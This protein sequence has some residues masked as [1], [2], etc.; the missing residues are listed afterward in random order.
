MLREMTVLVVDDEPPIR[1]FITLMLGDV[2]HHVVTAENGRDAMMP[3]MDGWAFL[4]QWQTRPAEQRAPVLVIW[5]VHNKRRAIESGAQGFLAKPFD[6]D[7]LEA[8]LAVH[9]RRA[10]SLV[11]RMERLAADLLE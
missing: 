10:V 7:A 8:A 11:A 2:G 5:A 1:G 3:E 9:R 4:S 6:L